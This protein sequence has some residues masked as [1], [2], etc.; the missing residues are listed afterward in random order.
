[1]KLIHLLTI[2]KG[3]FTNIKFAVPM[4]NIHSYIIDS[5]FSTHQGEVS[6]ITLEKVVVS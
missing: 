6:L 2:L 1:M 4:K 5:N 3:E